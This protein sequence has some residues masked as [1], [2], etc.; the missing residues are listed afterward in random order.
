MPE[1]LDGTRYRFIDLNG[2]GLSGVL[3]DEDGGWRYKRNL[4]PVNSVI[5]EGERQNR[6]RFATGESLPSLPLP[7]H[8]GGGQQLLDLTGAGLLDLVAL[9]GPVAGYF[10][11]TEAETWES[12]RVFPSL[13]RINW[14]DP[15]LRFVDLTGDGLADVLITE[16]DVF[17]FYASLGRDGFAAEQRV[18]IP[19]DEDRGPRVVFA[20]G[21]QTVSL[22]D[23]CGDGLRDLVRVRNGEVC[24]WPNVGYGRFA[25]KVTMNASP[26]FTSQDGFDARRIHLADVDGSGTSDIVYTGPDGVQVCFNRC[27]NS[28]G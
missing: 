1:G 16:D 18:Y 7:A 6:A 5:V 22:A 13:P 8:L 24:Y 9:D 20:D 12:F 17:S 2:D 27:G 21:E 26:R 28:F 23:M 3:I 25:A 19:T 10:A 14:S 11:R 4:S 15:N